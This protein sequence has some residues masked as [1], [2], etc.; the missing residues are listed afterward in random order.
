MAFILRRLAFY[1]AAFVVAAAIN[2]ALPRLMP[3]N[4]VDIMFSQAEGRMPPALSDR[5]AETFGFTGEPLWSQFL[6]YLSSVFTWDLGTSIKFYPLLGRGG[7]RDT[8]SPGR[9]CS[10]ARRRCSASASARCSASTRPGGA[11]AGSTRSSRPPR[12]SCS[13]FRRSCWRSR[14]SSSS[15]SRCD[16][17]RPATPMPP[18][19]IPALTPPSSAASSAH[20]MMPVFSLV[21]SNLGGYLITMRNN[22]IG[23]L[24]E[25]YVVMGIAKGLSDARVRYNY[26]AR[27]A[28]LPS[29]TAFADHARPYPGR[30][31]GDRGGV[32]LSRP[33]QHALS[34]HHRQRLSADPGPASHHDA[35][36]PHGEL[37]SST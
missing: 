5:L 16:G 29:I 10:P 34:R 36:D 35:G 18:R 27:N 15:A 3:G 20:A 19:S 25:D 37:S 23:Q 33:R 22:M 31:A 14:R 1:L 30:L 13:R 32:Q 17:C 4:P 6:T 28:L 26:A 21:F 11:A 12:W 9:S 7:A 24:G 8:P 2:F